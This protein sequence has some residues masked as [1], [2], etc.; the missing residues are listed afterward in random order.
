MFK[1]KN[2]N[3]LYFVGIFVFFF[4]ISF[5][6]KLYLIQESFQTKNMSVLTLYYTQWCPYSR[7]FMK[8]WNILK[9]KYSDRISMLEMDCSK[10]T[11]KPICKQKSIETVPALIYKK[12]DINA[13]KYDSTVLYNKGM[14]YE[15]VSR[16]IENELL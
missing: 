3:L 2:N 14:N 1:I 11:N 9:E 5:F 10:D 12:Y 6:N 4:V 8:E 7:E 15:E 16:L 13:E